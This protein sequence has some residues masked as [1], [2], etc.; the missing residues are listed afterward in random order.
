MESIRFTHHHSS[1]PGRGREGRLSRTH[2]SREPGATNAVRLCGPWVP[3]LR[4]PEQALAR[5]SG[6]RDL[7]HSQRYTRARNDERCP[8]IP[9]RAR[10]AQ[11]AMECARSSAEQAPKQDEVGTGS[12]DA[13]SEAPPAAAQTSSGTDLR[14]SMCLMI[15]FGRTRERSAAGIFRPRDLAGEPVPVGRDRPAHPQR[16]QRAGDCAIHAAHRSRAGL[17]RSLRSRAGAAQVGG[18]PARAPGPVRESRASRCR[19]QRRASARARLARR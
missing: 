3:D 13:N 4:S 11:S 2:E 15:E 9:G 19:L 16:R 6:T 18:I 5:S 1:C 14:E 7:L 8:L 17:A 12:G 10:A